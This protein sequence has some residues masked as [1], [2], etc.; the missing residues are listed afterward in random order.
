MTVLQEILEW[1]Q[2]RPAWQRD[3]LRRLVLDGELSE[4]DID[5]LTEICKSSRGLAEQRDVLP[6]GREHVPDR[7]AGAPVSLVS[8]FHQRGVNALA[9]NQTLKFG[10]GL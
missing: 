3:A 2:E 1:S 6:L 7:T 10:P 8:I 5:D 9:D 4:E